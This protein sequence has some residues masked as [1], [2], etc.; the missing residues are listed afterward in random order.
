MGR[1]ADLRS[2]SPPDE[3]RD[4]V[5]ASRGGAGDPAGVERAGDTHG[6]DEAVDAERAAGSTRGGLRFL[7]LLGLPAF[8]TTLALTAVSTYAPP[9]LGV[10]SGPL[11]TG[12]VIGGEGLAGLVVPLLVGV[13]NDRIARTVAGRLRFVLFAAPL[14]VAALLA[15][16]TDLGP[17]LII[18]GAGVYFLGHFAYL[19]PY[20]AL[21][22]DIVPSA[23]SG[24]SRS[25][26]SSWRFAGLGVALIGGGFLLD[27]WVPAVFILAAGAIVVCTALFL[28]GLRP[29]RDA[30]VSRSDDSLAQTFRVLSGL[31]R[32]RGVA[33]I[34]VATM[35]WNFAL[36]G[37]KAF[38][39]LFFT[40][41]LGRSA[42]FVSAVV[43]PLVALGLVAAL[44]VA[45][46]LAD[47][48]GHA[49][50]LSAAAAVYGLGLL[51]AGLSHSIGIVPLP[52]AAAGAVMTLN[53]SAL[54]RVLPAEHHGVASGLF[55]LSRGA[56]CLLGPLVVGVVIQTAGALFPAT[57]GYDAMW[58][59]I[60]A[61]VLLTVPPAVVGSRRRTPSLGT[62]RTLVSSGKGTPKERLGQAVGGPA[63]L[64]V[65]VL[66]AAVLA[67]D[68]ADRS[69]V[70]AVAAEL[71]QAL[72]INNT[73]IGLLV[74]ASTGA[75]AL[76]TLPIGILVDRV[77]RVRLLTVAVVVWSMATI[78]GGAAT[79]YVMLL[80]AR[81]ALGAVVATAFPA[82]SSLTGDLFPAA[83]R[84]RMWGY[85]LSGELI[86][87]AVGL[88]LSGAIAGLLSWRF[89]FWLLALLGFVLAAV[90]PR[91]LPEPAR[92]G[93]SPA[94]ARRHRHRQRRRG[95][96][97]PAWRPP[98]RVWPG[99]RGRAGERCS[100]RGR[101]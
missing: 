57:H 46:R 44:P 100:R 3:S 27:L 88:G 84:G 70:G 39:V 94:A 52:A 73:E 80:V 50:V 45:G 12:A 1:P 79:S 83:D 86:G 59:V 36:Q 58:F 20:E 21:Y 22:P 48:L 17:A 66:F 15:V 49:G 47:R 99:D 28:V 41:G 98:A 33:V 55:L 54:M 87:T 68:A 90:L 67:L 77:A 61:A 26:A 16:A 2:D 78:V 10:R 82:V 60:A 81:L 40:V 19:T 37:L 85:I 5:S 29:H 6:A 65:V 97:A 69:T 25:V 24:R 101:P 91:L 18:A 72:N 63:R 23:A 56:G 31:L 71:H 42:T 53:Y 92:G 95:R 96:L 74:T 13:A 14:C 8:G 64:R 76:A 7:L 89:S 9:L 38:V 93:Q 30:A 51:A 11:V 4:S 34:I 35:L 62:G 43:F 75:G 32:H